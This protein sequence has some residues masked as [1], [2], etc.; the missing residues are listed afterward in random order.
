MGAAVGDYDNDGNEDLYVTAFNYGVYLVLAV[1]GYNSWK[2][3][4]ANR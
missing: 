3:S 1:A 4:L 2:R